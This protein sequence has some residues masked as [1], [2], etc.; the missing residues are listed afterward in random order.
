VLPT[1]AVEVAGDSCG[2]AHTNA[3]LVDAARVQI[4]ELSA[5]K[6]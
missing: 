3:E 4:A 5:E 6:S 1:E 2:H